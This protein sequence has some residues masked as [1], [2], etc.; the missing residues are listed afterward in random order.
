M[1][2][3]DLHRD[4]ADDAVDPKAW[5]AV[6]AALGR[7]HGV[8]TPPSL[9]EIEASRRTGDGPA[10]LE[11]PAASNPVRRWIPAL[12]AA[13]VVAIA[14]VTWLTSQPPAGHTP[15][16]LVSRD[17]G[18]YYRMMTRTFEPRVVCDSSAR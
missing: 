7:V 5:E 1:T 3:N 11:F 13:A 8:G 14:S 16:T 4:E 2:T 9:D 18:I 15:T 10:P 6:E 17:A 12:A